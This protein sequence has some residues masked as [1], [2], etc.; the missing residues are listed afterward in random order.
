MDRVSN[1]NYDFP[2]NPSFGGQ[3]VSP[4]AGYSSN[5]PRQYR[6]PIALFVQKKLDHAKTHRKNYDLYWDFFQ[7]L[8][9]AQ[10]WPNRRIMRGGDWRA[11]LSVNYTFAI[12]ESQIAV[13]FEQEPKPYVVPNSFEQY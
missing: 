3:L 7:R 1:L 10:H 13:L 11:F 6:D 8:Y 2:N 9:R 4:V 12:I 5:S